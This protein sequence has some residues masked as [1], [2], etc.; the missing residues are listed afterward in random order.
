MLYR[1]Y[2]VKLLMFK[3]MA[4][5][6]QKYGLDKFCMLLNFG[7]QIFRTFFISDTH[8]SEFKSIRNFL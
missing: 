7:Y 3:Q 8:L 1:K 2:S 5:M 4:K 6:M